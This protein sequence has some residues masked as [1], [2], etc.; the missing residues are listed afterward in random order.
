M[1]WWAKV[2]QVREEDSGVA[3]R[4]PASSL[5]FRRPYR[6]QLEAQPPQALLI[7]T[8]ASLVCP[9]H[10]PILP[11]ASTRCSDQSFEACAPCSAVA[12]WVGGAKK[13]ARVSTRVLTCWSAGTTVRKRLVV[14]SDGAVELSGLQLANGSRPRRLSCPYRSKRRV[15][16]PPAQRDLEAG[17]PSSGQQIIRALTF[18]E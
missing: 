3:L 18:V 6:V 13:E 10:V 1:F 15:R 9:A 2:C 11:L 7:L 5:A 12:G 8:A 16:V 4:A 17:C 14:E